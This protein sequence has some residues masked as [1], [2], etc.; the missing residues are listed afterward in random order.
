MPGMTD[1]LFDSA[2]RLHSHISREHWNGRAIVGPDSGIRFNARFGRF[3]K[4]YLAFLP[5]T[6]RYSYMQAQ[7]YWIMDNWLLHDLTGAED[8]AAMARGCSEFV[9]RSQRPEGFWDYPNPEWRGRIATVEGDIASIALLESYERTGAPELLAGAERWGRYLVE[10]VGFEHMGSMCAVNYFANVSGGMVPNN[11]TLTLLTM[12]KLEKALGEERFRTLR[13]GMVEWLRHAQLDSGELPY[14]LAGS[15]G[16]DRIHF[17]CYQYNAFEFMDLVQYQ[18]LTGDPIVMEILGKL[19]RYLATGVT[20]EGACR[21]SCHQAGPEV[22]YYGAAL[23]TALGHA[24]RLG[25]GD[26]RAASELGYRRLLSLIREDGSLRFFSR[27][28]YRYLS[29]RR[30]YP[31]NLAMVLN[32][33]LVEAAAQRSGRAG[34]ALEVSR[35]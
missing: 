25:L 5:W 18:A 12:A 17:L 35:S 21:Y 24:T 20:E 6:D 7:G 32:H 27:G 31:R 29:D 22:A 13:E 34:A 2:L 33:L 1:P 4:S 9:L 15:Q 3:L 23:A 19:A 26:Y 10:G 28:N 16:K 14:A 30:S 11:S 8:P